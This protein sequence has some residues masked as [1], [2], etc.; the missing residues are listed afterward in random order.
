MASHNM[1][2]LMAVATCVLLAVPASAQSSTDN[3]TDFL[4]AISTAIDSKGG[5]CDGLYQY[6]YGNALP[7]GWLE[8]TPGVWGKNPSDVE[9]WHHSKEMATHIGDMIGNA[10][11]V[12]D[13]T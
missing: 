1:S 10:K 6:T 11:T 3:P 7:Q 13:I 2:I 4:A 9:P 8:Q 5:A 12:V